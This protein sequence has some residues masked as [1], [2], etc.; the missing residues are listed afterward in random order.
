MNKPVLMWCGMFAFMS[1]AALFAQA[2]APPPPAP[3]EKATVGVVATVSA[4]G[5]LEAWRS[6]DSVASPSVTPREKAPAGA[7]FMLTRVEGQTASTTGASVGKSEKTPRETRYLLLSSPGLD[8]TPHLNHKVKIVG[9]IA[10]QPS[11]GASP[12]ERVADPSTRE[13][14]LP[15]GQKSEAYDYNLIEVSSL[16]MVSTACGS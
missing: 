8:F 9:T 1:G 4:T 6:D 10:P 16:T 12:A 14:N 2:S 5:C 13:T 11:E 15:E 3:G 7:H